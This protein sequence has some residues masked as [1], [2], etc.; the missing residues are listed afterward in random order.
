[1]YVKPSSRKLKPNLLPMM[2]QKA[3]G[4]SKLSL[5]SSELQKSGSL[6]VY[7]TRR[8]IAYTTTVVFW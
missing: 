7:P 4:L 1:M 2:V 8:R 3:V 6:A 5:T